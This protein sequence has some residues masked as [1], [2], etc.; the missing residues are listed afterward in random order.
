[1]TISLLIS[2]ERTCNANQIGIRFVKKATWKWD[3][4]VIVPPMVDDLFIQDSF[5]SPGAG[6][7]SAC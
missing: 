2:H 5:A 6:Y 4:F 1:M 3:A 7:V